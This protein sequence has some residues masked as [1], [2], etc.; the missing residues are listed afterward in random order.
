M[1]F[2]PKGCGG[3]FQLTG[4]YGPATPFWNG[5]TALAL[6][7][8]FRNGGLSVFQPSWRTTTTAAAAARQTLECQNG[9][10]NLLTF[11]TQFGEHF[12]YVHD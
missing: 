8:F 1:N 3:L 9:F 10:F 11:H 4:A 12:I 7:D 2:A 6:G 5:L